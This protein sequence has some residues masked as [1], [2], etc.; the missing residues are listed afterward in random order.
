MKGNYRS[1]TYKDESPIEYVRI[2]EH[3]N[4]G[5]FIKTRGRDKKKHEI[6]L[7]LSLKRMEEAEK[8]DFIRVDGKSV[9]VKI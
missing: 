3:L 9:L 6:L 8:T 4:I 5:R 1:K 2:K 7:K